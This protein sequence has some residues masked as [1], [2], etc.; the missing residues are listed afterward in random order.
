M[1][2]IAISISWVLGIFLGSIVI[3]PFWVFF[4]SL[5]PFLLIFRFKTKRIILLIVGICLLVLFSG[6]V[7]YPTTIPVI[8]SLSKFNND[9]VI[10]LHGQI[11]TQPEVGDTINHLEVSIN[12]I[13]IDS[14]W[15]DIEANI[16]IFTP[17]YP[18]YKYGD[19]LLITG[20]LEDA[21]VFDDFNYQAYL[22]SKDI[23]STMFNPIIELVN[24]KTSSDFYGWVYEL[25]SSLSDSLSR[26]L[27]EPQATLAQGIVFGIRNN[28]PDS[29]KNNLSITG[30]AHLLAISGINLSIITGLLVSFGIWLFGRRHYYY[31]WLALI[32]IWFYSLLTGAQ[33]PVIRAAIMASVFLFAELFG[34]QKSSFVA[35]TFC[36]ALMLAIHPSL[37]FD[38]SFQLSFLAMSGLILITPLLQNLAHKFVSFLFKTEGFFSKTIILILDSFC[39]TLGAL[40]AVWPIIAFN[41]GIISFAGPLA[42]FLIAP[43]LSPIIILGIL[44]SLIGLISQSVSQFVGWITWLF[45][46][47]MIWM[48][49][50]FASFPYAALKV[51][52]PTNVFFFGYYF[53][54]TAFIWTGSNIKHLRKVYPNMVNTLEH[55]VFTGSLNYAKISKKFIILPLLILAILISSI[56]LSLPDNNLHISFLDV[57]EGDAT[58]IQN[59]YQN[60]L[61]DGGPSPQAICTKLSDKIPFWNRNIDLVILTHPHLDHL[62][63]LI[64]VIK[65]YQ[66]KEVLSLNTV[67]NSLAY[68]EWLNYLE[69]HK[70]PFTFAH[71]GQIVKLANEVKLEILAPLDENLYISNEN[72]ENNCI[73]MRL[74]LKDISFLLTA[75]C[76]WSEES[77][78]L[79]HRSIQPS[80]VLKVAHHG[81]KTSTSR[82]FLAVTSPQLAIISVGSDNRFG[83]P[84]DQVINRLQE[85]L[86]SEDK[87]YRTDEYGTIELTTDGGIL[88][89]KTEK[90]NVN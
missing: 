56:S 62:S 50:L 43:V 29:L 28:L 2:L 65:R 52:K 18:E 54:V 42:T 58:L 46:S 73:V 66:V 90:T 12:K 14:N 83:H 38:V 41:F 40:I 8:S 76:E 36:A 81:S 20:K 22:A 80:T 30:T 5:I 67:T 35:L 89:L 4:S 77:L 60:I 13:Q 44:T 71:A 7:Y 26:A 32:L 68:Q 33:A 63:G 64:E 53:C 45:L 55:W 21:P 1:Y 9:K 75:D 85:S 11:T 51:G 86:G 39:I 70:I 82:Q 61:I 37:L 16:L 34:R 6:A 84:D 57:G 78:L 27:P 15:Q 72:Q 23:F 17:R 24:R 31:I 87:I 47:Y 19:E 69:L 3:V 74:S 10:L 88:Y 79:S 49:N 48:V 25:R 59:G